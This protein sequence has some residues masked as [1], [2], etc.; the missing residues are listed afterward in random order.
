[1]NAWKITWETFFEHSSRR[2]YAKELWRLSNVKLR[3]GLIAAASAFIAA[4]SWVLLYVNGN[5]L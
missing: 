4:I 3:V 1:M 2:S 5:D